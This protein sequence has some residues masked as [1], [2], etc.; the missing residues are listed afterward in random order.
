MTQVINNLCKVMDC[1][2]KNTIAQTDRLTDKVIS[3]CPKNDSDFD[4]FNTVSL[5][6]LNYDIIP[7]MQQRVVKM[8]KPVFA[9]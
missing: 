1:F 7:R 6:P 5:K 9:K 2:I 3:T 8:L 4:Q